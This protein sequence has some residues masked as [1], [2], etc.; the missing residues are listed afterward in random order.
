MS[1][2][3][4]QI[5]SNAARF[6]LE[7]ADA[8]YEKGE[9]QTFYN[10]F[11]EVF[12]VSRRSVA[13]Y[14]EHVKLLG[15][16][17]GFVDLLWPGVLIVEQKSRGR[18]LTTA[19]KQAGEYF[20]ALPDGTKPRFQLV[21]DF[22][23]FR[24]VDRDTREEVEFSLA[25]LPRHI[26]K[27]SFLLGKQNPKNRVQEQLDLA[28]AQ[29]IVKIHRDLASSGY[30]APDME[31][32][33]TRLVYCL[34]ADSAGVFQP[35]GRFADLIESS[36][37]AGA[38]LGQLLSMVFQV[39][40][41][42]LA[43][44]Q[45]NLPGDLAE[46]PYVNGGLF[47]R[48][49]AI[50]RF[51]DLARKQIIDACRF[52]WSSISPAIFGSLYQSVLDP[53]E[54]RDIGAYS[55]TETNILKVLDDLFLDKLRAELR[56]L[57]GPV[58]RRRE[59][60]E[61]FREKLCRIQCFDPACGCGNF[62]AV[63]YRELRQIELEAMKELDRLGAIGDPSARKPWVRLSQFHGIEK[64]DY[65]AR[66]AE[67]SLWISDHLANNAASNALKIDFSRI[68]LA[69]GPAIVVG[70]ALTM[71]WTSLV[72]PGPDVYVFGN[73]PYKGPKQ[74]TD[75][76]RELIRKLSARPGAGG[77]LDYAC[78]WILKACEYAG[79]GGG[80]GLVSINS[81]VQGEQAGQL[82]PLV[83]DRFGLAIVFAHQPFKWLADT[84]R[85]ANVHVI[86]IGLGRAAAAPPHRR[87]FVYRDPEAA[88]SIVECSAISPYLIVGDRLR[89]PATVVQ[90]EPRP[91]NGLRKLSTGTKPI[92][93]GY[94][95]LTDEER[96]S[97]VR[98]EPGVTDFI[99]PFIG[100]D[101]FIYGTSRHLLVLES[102]TPK[103]LRAMPSVHAL[104]QKVSQYRRAEILRKDGSQKL[105]KPTEP[106]LVADP[107]RFHIRAFPSEPFLVIPEVSSE[108]RRYVPIGWL[109]PPAIPSNLVKFIERASLSDFALLTSAMHMAWLR[110]VGGK[111]EGRLRYSIGVVYN[112]FP[113]PSSRDDARLA[114]LGQVIVD[115]RDRLHAQGC[116]LADMYDGSVMPA[117]LQKAHQRVDEEVDRQYLGHPARD[118]SER[119]VH[120]LN[121]YRDLRGTQ[122][123][124]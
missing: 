116:S 70:D 73:P 37:D 32:L 20:D 114:S 28:A 54:R 17:G 21:C 59:R 110:T 94:Y 27:F 33:L 25:D 42:P 44:R 122:S 24:L 119:V 1:L 51:S 97:L 38:D 109:R 7:W 112:T 5:E 100:G 65:S 86:V 117:D 108:R 78:G 88:S 82:W 49:I 30:P 46:L 121:A 72:A 113:M 9:T 19:A 16:G 64:R 111:L 118:D 62:L 98:D 60:L 80:V 120:L 104:V 66:I 61:A 79:A 81:I 11:F 31:A 43:A 41:Q 99:H 91:I 13:R 36:A 53:R 23:T 77:T 101:E 48:V 4:K 76:E 2:T 35:R 90:E 12:G 15:G 92:D 74:Q 85:S 84:A 58:P 105:K 57:S 103:Q 102:A 89:D 26:Q 96:D 95:I 3:W 87:L 29:H 10:E 123:Q 71:D 34:F 18:D 69:N 68:P 22:Q 55:T 115:V 50:P 8:R 14:E 56:E 83:F 124:G 75:A 52:D 67:A 39:L 93:G 47:E 107:L 63:A 106:A 6:A 45:R 40:G